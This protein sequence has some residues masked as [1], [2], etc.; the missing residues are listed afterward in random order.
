MRHPHIQRLSQS[1]LQLIPKQL[2]LTRHH[3]HQNRS[4]LTQTMLTNSNSRRRQ[5][6]RT[7]A[8]H[9]QISTQLR[10]RIPRL[11]PRKNLS[12]RQ[13]SDV[14]V[15][16]QTPAKKERRGRTNGFGPVAFLLPPSRRR[17]GRGLDGKIDLV[18]SASGAFTPSD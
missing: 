13:N 9:L 17:V 14:Q 7:P 6:R 3:R 1:Q 11:R 15:S 5:L 18:F 16:L 12:G 8:N 2:P 10:H 4:P